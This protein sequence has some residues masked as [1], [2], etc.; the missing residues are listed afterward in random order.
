MFSEFDRATDESEP[1][2]GPVPCK[3]HRFDLAPK[4]G[5]QGSESIEVQLDNKHGVSEPPNIRSGTMLTEV[6]LRRPVWLLTK[7]LRS[8]R[9]PPLHRPPAL[10]ACP[11]RNRVTRYQVLRSTRRYAADSMPYLTLNS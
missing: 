6:L 8:R 7:T 5:Q 2:D 10:R 9:V 11:V 3:R 4:D 1:V